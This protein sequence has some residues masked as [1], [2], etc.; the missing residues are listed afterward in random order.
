MPVYAL[1]E[2]LPQI[3]PEAYHHP[4]AVVI[5]QVRIGAGASIWPT[6]VLRGDSGAI[7]IGEQ[8][9]IQDGVVIH[10][11]AGDDTVIGNG[12][13]VG[14]NAHIE[15]AIIEDGALIGSGSVVL[16]GAR[17]GRYALVAAG[18]VVAPGKVVPALARA[19]GVP[20]SITENVMSEGHSDANVEVYVQQAQRYLNELR[21]LD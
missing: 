8:T 19:I 18:A 11:R 15:G 2:H 3:H 1:G 17:I 13:V 20:A 9:N 21:R 12:V 14:H 6:A 10:A 16:P 5:G 7:T 4:D